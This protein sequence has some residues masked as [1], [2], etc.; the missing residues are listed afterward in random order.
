MINVE[1]LQIYMNELNN[2][3]YLDLR[4]HISIL[5]NETS[6]DY[7]F[8]SMLNDLSETIDIDKKIQQA[9]VKTPTKPGYFVLPTDYVE[10]IPVIYTI[11]KDISSGECE[12]ASFI[13]DY[14]LDD[15]KNL[16]EQLMKPFCKFLIANYEL[17]KK[18]YQGEQEMNDSLKTQSYAVDILKI[19]EEML[20]VIDQQKKINQDV[21]ED[22]IY[23]LTT[24]ADA[25]K[26]EDLKYINSLIVAFSYMVNKVKFLKFYSIELKQ[27]MM[28]F[29]L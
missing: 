15:E 12:L 10:Y 21:K 27:K 1:K 26:N 3:K 8:Q 14:F 4:K 23:I 19:T 20:A 11:L 16:I 6:D 25:C 17:I 2:G 18:E 7:V 9:R 22:A 29:Y 13:K 24:L 5:V 28:D